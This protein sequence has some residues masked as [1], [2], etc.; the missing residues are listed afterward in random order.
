[1]VFKINQK[2]Q[3]GK[4]RTIWD[5]TTPKLTWILYNYDIKVVGR[6]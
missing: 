4:L 6:L 1:M 3:I 5:Q 2:L